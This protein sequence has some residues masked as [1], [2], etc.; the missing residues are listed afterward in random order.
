MP[1]LS[2]IRSPVQ[3]CF[4]SRSTPPDTLTPPGSG[5]W[6]RA[7][8]CCAGCLCVQALT[9]SVAFWYGLEAFK[10]R[11]EVVQ[12]EVS[13]PLLHGSAVAIR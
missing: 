1:F 5:V 11:A 2:S 7:V 13:P 3:F 4:F 8:L 12:E 9:T 6:C 10:L